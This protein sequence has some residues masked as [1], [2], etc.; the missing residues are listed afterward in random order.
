MNGDIENLVKLQQLFLYRQQKTK[1]RENLPPE[2]AGAD[3]EYR[4]RLAA[5]ETL[6]K[7]ILDAEAARRTGEAALADLAEKQKKYQ[8]QLMAVKNSREYGAMLNEIDQVK[9]ALR[10]AEDQVVSLMETLESSGK[11]LAEREAALPGQTQEHEQS[12]AGWRETQKQ[13]DREIAEAALR[14]EEL[15]KLFP[16]KTLSEFRRLF[17]RKGGL[18]V[19]RAVDGSCSACHVRLRPALYQALRISGEILTCDSCKRILFYQDDAAALV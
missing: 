10:E 17:D 8:A 4:E 12:L 19:V 14:I 1:E 3:R 7:T 15:E 18:A 11:D 5:I 9:K 16:P 13:I 6:K 2:F